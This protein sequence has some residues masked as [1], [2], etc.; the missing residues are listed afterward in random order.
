MTYSY[1][2]RERVLQTKTKEGLS[3]GEVSA[4]FCV[5]IAS[6]VRWSKKIESQKTRHKPSTKVDIE[7]L[8]KDIAAYPDG[9]Q[10]ERSERLGVTQSAIWYALQRLGVT[11]KKN[12]SA[13]Q[14]KSR[15]TL[16]LLP[17]SKRL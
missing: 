16:C 12:P 17:S 8:K 1:D 3:F 5:G 14:S 7:A 6:V 15:K 2:F 4:R 13:S 9:Y 10:Y 11:Y